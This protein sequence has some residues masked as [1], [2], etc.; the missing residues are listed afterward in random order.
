M[1]RSRRLFDGHGLTVKLSYYGP[2]LSMPVHSHEFHQVSF[3]LAGG[4]R[5]CHAGRA[6]EMYQP[7]VGFKPAG[8]EHD[9]L[10]HPEDGALMLS[11]NLEPG[12]DLPSD[13]LELA[14]WSWAPTCAA[15]RH[16]SGL[17]ALLGEHSE[18]S[19]DAVWDLL[20]LARDAPRGRTTTVPNWLERIRARLDDHR[21]T[22]GIAGL[23][24]AEGLHRVHLSRAFNAHYGI[25]PSIYRARRRVGHALG[26]IAAGHGICA[27]ATDAGFA[28]QSHFSRALKSQTGFTPNRLRRF[29][30]IA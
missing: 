3:L 21:D 13:V 24:A 30:A 8:L 4:L 17:A 7:G 25:P 18:S 2:G 10:Y 15:G 23:A 12:G 29:L 5:E 20:A 22:E 6:L 28:D 11:V 14:N 16:S 1:F 19:E 9:N 27:A 26:L